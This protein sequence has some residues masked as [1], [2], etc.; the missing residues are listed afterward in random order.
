MSV[1]VCLT[2]AA[3][4]VTAA[5]QRDE[6]PSPAVVAARSPQ[7]QAL[8]P[9][10]AGDTPPVAATQD[11]AGNLRAA[12]DAPAAPSPPAPE[13]PP[14]DTGPAP[15]TDPSPLMLQ[16]AEPTVDSSVFSP[17]RAAPEGA[18]AASAGSRAS[19]GA[20]GV[21]QEEESGPQCGAVLCAVGEE[22][23]NASCGTCVAPGQR[24]S[25]LLCG[26][27]STL[28]AVECG[29]NTCDVGETCCNPSCG[30]CTAAGQSCSKEPCL[31]GLQYPDFQACG[32][33][34]CSAGTSC[35]NPSCGTCV[36]PGEVCDSARCD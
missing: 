36:A 21:G 10:V 29:R 6:R 27:Q 26:M 14:G 8:R 34:T 3:G 30:I 2:L 20:A 4:A 11:P 17:P 33:I 19:V 35:C 5:L 18:A 15:G 16:W 13:P 1:A 12:E 7:I 31:G 22:C 32:M 9:P 23:C 28:A 25:Q 24:C